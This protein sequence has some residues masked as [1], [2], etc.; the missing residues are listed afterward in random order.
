M[1]LSQ[2]IGHVNIELISGV[3][4]AVLI[5]IIKGWYDENFVRTTAILAMSAEDINAVPVCDTHHNPFRGGGGVKYVH[6]NRA[7][8]RRRRKGKSGISDSKKNMVASPTGLGPENDCASE[9]QQQLQTTDPCSRLWQCLTS[10]RPQVSDSNKNLV[11]SPRWM[12]YSKR[13]TGRLTSVVTWNLTRYHTN[14][15]RWRRG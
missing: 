14:T 12:L 8:R 9:G 11:V 13:Q 15:W 1:K 4:V 6:R 7:C 2:A 10:T 3:S 5:S